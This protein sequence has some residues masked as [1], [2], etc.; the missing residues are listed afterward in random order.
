MITVSLVFLTLHMPSCICIKIVHLSKQV[1][2]CI[3]VNLMCVYPLNTSLTFSLLL[4]LTLVVCDSRGRKVLPLLDN[5]DI[6]CRFYS[7]ATLEGIL[8]KLKELVLKYR[9]ISCLIAV[10]VNDL[11][12]SSD[13]CIHVLEI[14]FIWLIQ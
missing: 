11:T 2:V 13:M 1:P 6:I 12:V 7:G 4:K 9:P 8:P 5:R 14:H 3:L 10:G